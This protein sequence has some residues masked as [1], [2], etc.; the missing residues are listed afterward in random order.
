M[1]KT[2]LAEIQTAWDY[3][4]T[5][6]KA[7]LFDALLNAGA[8]EQDRE[9]VKAFL[10]DNQAAFSGWASSA[11][12]LLYEYLDKARENTSLAA[13]KA[14]AG[15]ARKNAA[16]MAELAQEIAGR[17]DATGEELAAGLKKLDELQKAA[18]GALSGASASLRFSLAPDSW[19]AVEGSLKQRPGTFKTRYKLTDKGQRQELDFSPGALTFIAAPSGHGKTTLLMNIL[20]DALEDH[21]DKRHWLFSF[22]EQAEVVYLK[23]FNVWAGEEFSHWNMGALEHYYHPTEASPDPESFIEG[24]KRA[25]FRSKRA[26]FG[27]LVD[28]GRLNIKQGDFRAEELGAAIVELADPENSPG[29]VM[30]DYAQLLY[31][32]NP[33][34]QL[35]RTEELKQICLMLK[36]VAI[37][38]QLCIVLAAQFN[39]TVVHPMFMHQTTLADASDIEKAASKIIGLWNGEKPPLLGEKESSSGVAFT[40]AAGIKGK[41]DGQYG[42]V[43]LK[44]LK[45]RTG[46]S[47]LWATFPFDGNRLNINR[48]PVKFGSGT[49]IEKDSSGKKGNIIEEF[50]A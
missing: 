9:T 1:K 41:S 49:P 14:A 25:V 23:E 11:Q 8:G 19:A 15:E 35:Q 40:S 28:S 37:K 30:I 16:A 46:P 39:R 7:G 3:T 33:G 10:E 34:K 27:G 47:D 32:D 36:E 42:T 48:K 50:P 22:E 26:A 38:T 2:T 20:A 44:I 43:F 12:A 21:P 45:D 18:A 17:P 24:G 29:L 31:L 13:G 4:Q 6:D 5:K